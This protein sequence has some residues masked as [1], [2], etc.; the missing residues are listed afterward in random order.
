MI[1]EDEMGVSK[2][3]NTSG[4]FTLV[5]RSKSGSSSAKTFGYI[6]QAQVQTQKLYPLNKGLIILKMNCLL[7]RQTIVTFSTRDNLT[8]T[9]ASH[10]KRATPWMSLRKVPTTFHCVRTTKTCERVFGETS[11][12]SGM[13]AG[14]KEAMTAGFPA[15]LPM[16]LFENTVTLDRVHLVHTEPLSCLTWVSQT[17]A[18]FV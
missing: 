7:D 6:S 11:G 9:L 5:V 10:R 1:Q 12:G 16:W 13:Q 14:L 4:A 18:C 8:I 3:L 15:N 17:V 2:D